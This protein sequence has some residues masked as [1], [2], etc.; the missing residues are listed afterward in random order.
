MYPTLLKENL[1]SVTKL[2]A[3]SLISYR[4]HSLNFVSLNLLHLFVALPLEAHF[5]R[6]IG[7][8]PFP[9]KMRAMFCIKSHLELSKFFPLFIV[10]SG[11]SVS[12]A[13]K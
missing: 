5:T 3:Y 6:G 9:Y 12:K 10:L 8:K 7:L 1:K 2:K 4:G 13:N 11:M